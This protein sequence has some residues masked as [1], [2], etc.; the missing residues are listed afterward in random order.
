MNTN[1]ATGAS[2]VSPHKLFVTVFPTESAQSKGGMLTT[3]E[4]LLRVE[5][6]IEF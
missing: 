6:D 1:P 4:E 5:E 3:L 2:P